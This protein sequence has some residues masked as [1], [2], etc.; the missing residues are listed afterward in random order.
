[1]KK[2]LTALICAFTALSL[3]DSPARAADSSAPALLG[4]YDGWKAYRFK[5]KGQD[6]CFMSRAPEKQEGKFSKRDEV[7]FFV[8]RWSADKDK[9]VVS[10]SNGY[11][12]KKDSTATLEVKGKTFKLFTDGTMAWTKD[13]AED[14]AAVKEIKAGSSMTVKGTS[15][16]GTE[17]TDTYSLKGS[18]EAYKAILAACAKKKTKTAPAKTPEKTPEKGQEKVKNETP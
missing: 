14:D 1:V 15:S 3:A 7:L 8:T 4:A 6:V 13:A 9:N 11:T 12:F 5:D 10:L 2:T 18:G 17:T 16:R